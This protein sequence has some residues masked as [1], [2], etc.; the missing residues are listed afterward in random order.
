MNPYEK[1]GVDQ[2]ETPAGIKKAFR[3]KAKTCHPDVAG[4]ESREEFEE[5]SAAYSL[6]IDLE[7]RKRFDRTGRTESDTVSHETKIETL[8]KNKLS[9]ILAEIC[10]NLALVKNPYFD[11]EEEIEKRLESELENTHRAIAGLRADINSLWQ[12][13][14]RFDRNGNFYKKTVNII[15]DKIREICRSVEMGRTHIEVL[16]LA[17]ELSGGIKYNPEK[18]EPHEWNVNLNRFLD[19]GSASAAYK[20][21]DT[22]A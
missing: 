2:R 15:R 12:F 20:I 14:K 19:I 17:L 22:M 13:R 1:L 21:F 9:G 5:I 4:E 10:S 3:A 11:V 8:A 16:E 18:K 7:K 6:L